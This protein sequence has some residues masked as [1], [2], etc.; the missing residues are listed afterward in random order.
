MPTLL[1][2]NR[3]SSRLPVTSFIG[4]LN[5]N[6]ARSV[7]LTANELEQCTL[8][9]VRLA[10]A[11]QITFTVNP[12][13]TAADNQ[14]EPVLGGSKLLRGSGVPN[15]VV[16]GSIGDLFVRTDGGANTTLYVKE[17]GNNTNTGWVAK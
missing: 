11:N 3:T 4:V 8:T 10:A 9:L 1:I 13:S 17:S 5:P 12:S 15:S 6:Q 14:A 16:V 7:A 2:T